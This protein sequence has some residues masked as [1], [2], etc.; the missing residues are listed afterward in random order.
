MGGNYGDCAAYRGLVIAV[1]ETGGT[2]KMFTV[3]AAADESQGA[4]WMGGAAPVVDSGG[5]IWVSA[6]NGSVVLS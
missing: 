1:P 2:P 5:D 6:G 3:D 4:I